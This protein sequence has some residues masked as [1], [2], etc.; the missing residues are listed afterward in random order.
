MPHSLSRFIPASGGVVS[1]LIPLIL[2]AAFV[3]SCLGC[4]SYMSPTRD[5]PCHLTRGI[6]LLE[7]GDYRLNTQ[8]PFL[9]NILN[10]IPLLF[11]EDLKLPSTQSEEWQQANIQNCF[12]TFIAGNGNSLRFT[13]HILNPARYG[14]VA[15]M[16]ITGVIL[17]IVIR[18]NWGIA[19]ASIFLAL[20][21][22]E[23]NMI[24]HSSLVTTDAWVVFLIFGATYAL[25]CYAKSP[26]KKH[27]AIFVISAFISLLAKYSAVPT[28]FLWLVL[29]YAI[30]F[31]HAPANLHFTKRLM[32]SLYIP[33]AVA[34][35]WMLLLWA[36]YGFRFQTMAQINGSDKARTERHLEISSKIGGKNL[37]LTKA[38]Q[39]SY[40]SVPLP[41]PEYIGGFLGNVVGH[42]IKG[43][44]TFLL[45]MHS[46]KGWWYY[47]PL[48]MLIKMPVPILLGIT[49]LFLYGI[50]CFLSHVAVQLKS[51]NKMPICFCLRAEH[52]LI[53]VPIFYF[54]LSM[55]SS[56]NLGL[57]HVLPVIPFIALAIGI[58]VS[59]YWNRHL[60]V[61]IA[62]IILGIWFAISSLRI[63]PYYLEYFNELI[64]GPSNGYKYL[65]DSNLSWK[66]DEF[67][68][69]DYVK[70][71][72]EGTAA[73]INPLHEV[74]KGT[75]IIDVDLLMGREEIGRPKTAWIRNQFLAGTIKP[76]DRIAYTYMV[77][78]F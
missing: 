76:V 38:L 41:F 53:L 16:A 20:C 73:Y 19:A 45:G 68:V 24:A 29:L 1:F 12:R 54:A 5:E 25:F 2:I 64:G 31:R 59:K 11:I 4:I 36:A 67:L 47:F 9:A 55:K 7:T 34:F 48:V 78:K 28:A 32:R 23:P 30:V 26:G 49:A 56:I 42:N 37:W 72:P 52:I 40:L 27:L 77:F 35:I 44:D 43:H 33:I 71:L 8:H 6:M 17:F 63:Y 50:F 14:A 58:L 70:R 66:Q 69:Q 10:A 3:I 46:K 39:T 75:V 57:R 62:T 13:T 60:Y 74:Q 21:M 18:R 22:L 65:V 51:G 61:R 15:L